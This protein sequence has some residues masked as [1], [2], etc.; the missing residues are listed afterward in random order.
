MTGPTVYRTPLAYTYAPFNLS[1]KV[2][3]VFSGRSP[4]LQR[5]ISL[6]SHTY[7]Q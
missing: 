2:C 6:S 4:G 1:A 5:D 7:A 3:V